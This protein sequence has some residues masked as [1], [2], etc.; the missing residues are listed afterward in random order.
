MFPLPD[1]CWANAG[2][3][4]IQIIFGEGFVAGLLQNHHNAFRPG[5]TAACDAA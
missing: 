5:K 3:V 1:R 2:L 4:S